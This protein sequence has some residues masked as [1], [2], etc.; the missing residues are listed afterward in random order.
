MS[1]IGPSGDEVRRR[2]RL[3]K[4]T[5][6]DVARKLLIETKET[7]VNQIK[8]GKF[9]GYYTGPT[10][11]RKLRVR[12]GA[13]RNSVG[14]V[15]K[16]RSANSLRAILRVGGARAGYAATQEYGADRVT[17]KSS[18]YMRVPIYPPAGK[19]LTRTGRLRSGVTPQLAGRGPRGGKIYTTTRF[20][21][22]FIFRSS[23]GN[24]IVAAKTGGRRGR[25]NLLYSLKRSVDIPN[26]LDA[27]RTA[28]A[29]W[30]AKIKQLPGRLE[31]E[32]SRKGLT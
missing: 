18:Q 10:V 6:D 20:G 2:I 8:T 11:G 19:A 27:G 5:T 24:L 1:M 14:G 31:L 4:E 17:A 32:L 13:L 16:G 26:R 22:T 15:V 21:R 30:R 7:W 12:T 3:V 25:L 29:L 28:R 23:K 9:R